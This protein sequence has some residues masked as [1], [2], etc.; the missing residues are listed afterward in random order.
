MSKPDPPSPPNPTDTAKAQTGTNVSTAVA[1][2]FLNNVNQ[3]TPT[4]SLNY[5]QSGSYGW[6]DPTTGATYNIP[7]FTATQTLS[8]Q[9]QAIQGQTQASQFNLASMA[10]NQSQRIGS[11]LS[12][13]MNLSGA[14]AAGQASSITNIPQAATSFDAGG[15][16][17][18]QL[19]L[20]G[21]ADPNNIQTNY[22][23]GDFSTDRQNVQDALMAR[24]NPQ[25]QLQT[26]SARSS[27]SPIRASATAVTPTTML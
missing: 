11:L 7:T 14:P 15:P 20:T 4:G 16:I 22:G 5:S 3:N 23:P 27:S 6:T 17:Q 25:L 8:P 2:A 21:A 9:E 12:N 19:N 18:S 10:N 1:N 13:E 24:I 26:A